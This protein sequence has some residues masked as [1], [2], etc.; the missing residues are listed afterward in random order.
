MS[1]QQNV[2][3][4]V[5][6]LPHFYNHWHKEKKDTQKLIYS[7]KSIYFFCKFLCRELNRIISFNTVHDL[8]L[9]HFFKKKTSKKCDNLGTFTQK[10]PFLDYNKTKQKREKS[11]TIWKK[12]WQFGVWQFEV[13]DCIWPELGCLQK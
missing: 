3:G 11:V 13:M 10:V 5:V 7:N 2:F 6:I 8:K 4:V 12:V 1:P 9:S